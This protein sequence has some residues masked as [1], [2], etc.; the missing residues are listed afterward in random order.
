LASDE[1]GEQDD[2]ATAEVGE[3]PAEVQ[4]HLEY[5]VAVDLQHGGF[6]VCVGVQKRA[7]GA[8]AGRGNQQADV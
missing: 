5:G 6:R 1:R 2:A 7:G 4:R 8:E 3:P